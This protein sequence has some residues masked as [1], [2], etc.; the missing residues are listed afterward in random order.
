MG[1]ATT[2]AIRRPVVLRAFQARSENALRA[3]FPG[4]HTR[5]GCRKRFGA[6]GQAIEIE[7]IQ[8]LAALENAA[9]GTEQV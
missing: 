7:D 2:V 1:V 6:H 3:D 9:K 5:Q 4:I 8:A